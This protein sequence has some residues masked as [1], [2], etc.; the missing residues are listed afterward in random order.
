[1]EQAYHKYRMA[2]SKAKNT[3][4][5]E[6]I[7]LP[8]EHTTASDRLLL[9]FTQLPLL[10]DPNRKNLDT[11]VIV[12]F[13]ED[14]TRQKII[15]RALGSHGV[16][17][18]FIDQ[19]KALCGKE[20]ESD[21][22]FLS[23]L[24]SSITDATAKSDLERILYMVAL[25]KTAEQLDCSKIYLSDTCNRI[26]IDAINFIC[27]GRGMSIPWLLAVRQNFIHSDTTICVVR[28]LRELVDL[29]VTNYLRLIP[30]TCSILDLDVDERPKSIQVLTESFLEGLDKDNPATVS[31]VIRTLGKVDT[32]TSNIDQWTPCALC[33]CPLPKNADDDSLYCK[34]CGGLIKAV[35]KH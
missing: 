16:E 2:T 14:S 4:K 6:R 34:A 27:T 22:F 29:E 32:A 11:F 5:V 3:P 7:L 8:F 19:N 17:C 33:F 18:E 23:L 25:V 10:R 9:Y 21:E 26:S 24:S 20:K 31:N 30:Q 15:Q 35:Q 12:S 13:E 28:P 1:M